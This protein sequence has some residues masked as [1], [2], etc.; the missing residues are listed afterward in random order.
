[1]LHYSL[2]DNVLT[3]R[4]DD[5]SAKTHVSESYNRDA[6]INLMLQRG[7]LLTKTDILAVFNNMEE[8]A[9]YIIENGGTLNLPLFSTGF[10]ITGVFEGATDAFDAERH[11]LKVNVR[12]GSLLREAEKQVKIS[13]MNT[14]PHQPQILEVKDSISGKVNSILSAGGVVEIAGIDIK[15]LGDKPEVGLYFTSSGSTGAN[16]EAKASTIITNK[17]SKLIALIPVLP[18][19][20]YKIKIVTQYN[21]GKDLKK[22]KVTICTQSFTVA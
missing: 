14:P 6:F 20:T 16:N 15:I 11:K 17:P 10:S 3:E 22:P 4:S 12:K 2:H 18:T 7:T 5:M 19:G 21:S 9:V 13:K 1:M 8:T